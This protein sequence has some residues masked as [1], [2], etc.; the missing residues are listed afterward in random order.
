MAFPIIRALVFGLLLPLALNARQEAAQACRTAPSTPTGLASPAQT[1]SAVTLT[2]RAATAPGGCAVTYTVYQNG[3][4]V[5]RG[6]G[7]T[8]YTAG[9]LSPA[10]AYTFAVAAADQ[11]GRSPRGAALTVKT[12]ARATACTAAPS[13]PTGLQ[14]VSVTASSVV[15]GWKAA[16]A[17]P[18][19]AVTYR[20]LQNGTP[21]QGN[22]AGTSASVSGLAPSTPYLFS[23]AAVD[24]A[25]V[26]SPSSPVTVTTPAGGATGLPRHL[27]MGYW[28][29][30]ND[31]GHGGVLRLRDV[32]VLYDLIA[33][34]FA[35]AT[36]TPGAVAF[37]LDPGL[38]FSV[39]EFIADVAQVRARGQHV[40]L[41]VGGQ[42]GTV[43]VADPASAAAFANSVNAL[44]GQYGFEGVDLDLENGLNATYMAQA[45]RLLRPGAIITMA[46]QTLD[47]QS[48]AAQYFKLALAVKD[49]LT[50]C[51]TQYYNSGTML[52]Y[53][54]KV[55]GQGGVDFFTALATIPL[56][57]G[58]RPDQIGLGV[59]ASANAAGSGYVAPAVVNAALDC[60]TGGTGCGSFKPPR[61][62]PALR[63]AMVWSINMDAA[64]GYSFG[65]A[66][67]AK[68]LSLP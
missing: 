49:L 22:L 18:G 53:D 67:K 35:D 24:Q 11:A 30:W 37:N 58:L 43:A 1:S 21:V 61:A 65:N 54:G 38:G 56:E 39:A 8:T 59:P 47:M 19:C 34:A 60:L 13:V 45:L 41:S 2:W 29:N 10:T 57:G 15:L 16:S 36:A 51:T 28:Q 52:G 33:V 50:L 32:P 12:R 25:G 48:T 4:R 20:V 3:L 26:S 55:Y 14:A 63:G 27:L 5:A 6:L 66:V 23:V 44:M 9:A 17:G 31:P 46:P 40:I 62:Y 7:A 42:N 64:G 68:L